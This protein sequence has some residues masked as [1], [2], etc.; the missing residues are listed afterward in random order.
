M[1]RVERLVFFGTPAFAVPAL[2]T[3]VA[4]GR[5]PALVVTQPARPA[6]RGR[7]LVEPPVAVRAREL[8]LTVAQPARVRDPE[9][10]ERLQALAPDLAVVVAFGQIFPRALLG[11]PRLGCVNVHA[12]LLPRW[13]GAA[14]I[15]AA[16]AAG[17]S[18]TGVSI[19]RMEQG[20]DTGPVLAERRTP[21]GPREDA[22][23]LAARLAAIGA[24]L[25]LEVVDALEH[26]RAV[27]TPQDD[28]RA[29]HAPK[30]A[31]G[32]DL[33]LAKSA[34]ELARE[35]RAFTPEP[36]TFLA[37]RGE[38]LKILAAHPASIARREPPAAI[39][40]VLSSG[41]DGVT[42]ATGDGTA[43]ELLRVQRAG[44]KPISGRDLA[45]GLRL[46]PGDR[47]S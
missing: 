15:A 22:G 45:N 11:L 3:L 12:S 9:F 19:Q 25:L 44:G 4:A 5:A 46:A 41:G 18:E 1:T 14:P 6:G 31:G 10:L 24:E 32:L 17:D 29:T 8:G 47:L 42:M 16:I 34:E 13:R 43:L 2:E 21:I 28:A 33:D 30:L 7:R 40:T 37:T 26:G 35:I 38:R 39:G 27:A 20:L 36:G 23:A